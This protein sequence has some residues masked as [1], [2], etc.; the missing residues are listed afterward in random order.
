MRSGSRHRGEAGGGWSAFPPLLATNG[1]IHKGDCDMRTGAI[2]ARGS[3]RALKWMALLGVVF[4]LGGG[5]A[6]AQVTGTAVI[7][8][9]DHG[10]SKKIVVVDL[11][12]DV[13]GTNVP[14]SS[15][16]VGTNQAER[17]TGLSGSSPGGDEF[18]LAFVGDLALGATIAYTP[19]PDAT[20]ELKM[21]DG[22]DDGTDPDQVATFTLTTTEEDNAPVLPSISPVTVKHGE[23][24]TV[25]EPAGKLP[26]VTGGSGTGNITYVASPA[27][28][29]GLTIVTT[30]GD[31]L[32]KIHGT[33]DSIGTLQVTWTATD[34]DSPAES[35]SRSFQL[36][37]QGVPAKPDEPTVESAASGSLMVSWSAPM[38]NGSAITHYQVR[39]QG[40][41]VS[42][43]LETATLAASAGTMTTLTGLTNGTEYS[44]GV[45]A[46]NGIGWSDYSDSGKG[47]PAA[48]AVTA[49]GM[50]T[51]TAT[52]G[53]GQVTLAWAAVTGATKYQY[54]YA[55]TGSTMGDWMPEDGQ[56]TMTATVD[57][58]TNGMEYT[59][60]VRAGNDAGYGDPGMDTG[61]PMAPPAAPTVEVSA[62]PLTIAEGGESTITATA[63]R[64]V[65][66]S[67][68]AVTVN[69]SVVPTAGATLSADSITIAVGEMS[70]TVTLTAAE[71]DDDY[72]DET[73]TV[74]ASGTGIAGNQSVE[75]TV[76]DNDT[77]PTTTDPIGRIIK[78][79]LDE[80]RERDID[81]KRL[82]I[83]EGVHTK[84]SVTIEWTDV[85]LQSLTAGDYVT[86]VLSTSWGGADLTE[87]LSPVEFDHDVNQHGHNVRVKIPKLAAGKRVASS[88]GS[89]QFTVGQDDDAE[90]EVFRFWVVNDDEFNPL[91]VVE[92]L[93][94]VIEDDETQGIELK[95]KGSGFIYEG[96]DDVVYEVNAKPARV[97]L[98]LDVRFDLEDV[99]GQ[100]VSSGRNRLTRAGATIEPGP[101]Q[102]ESV[103]ITLDKNDE[104]REDD[105]LKIMAEVVSYALDTGAYKGITSQEREFDVLD[106]HK[107]PKLTVSPPTGTVE[108]GGE[109]EL[110]VTINRNPPDT[111]AVGSETRQYTS[112]AVDVMLTAGAGTTAGMGDYQLPATVKF[113]KHSGKASDGWT[114][115]MTVMVK[116]LPDDDLDDGE[117]LAIDAMVS[118]TET[119]RGTD[120][121]SYH[122]SDGEGTMLTIK[123]ATGKL[124]WARTPEE[125]E[126]AVMAAKKAGMGDDMMFTAGEMIE[127][128]GNDLFGSA[129]GVSV[130]YTAMVEGDAV[131]ESVSGG[132]VTITAEKMGMAKVTITARA[133]R[134]SGAVTINDQTDPREASIT[135][136]LEVGLVALSIMLS[137]PEDMNMNLVE[138][139]MGGMVTATAN[140]DVTENTVVNLMRDRAMSSAGDEDFTVEPIT[141]MAGQMKGSTMVM[142]VEDNM[143][144]NEGN[145]AEE[146]VL[147]GMVADNAGE[148]TGDGVKFY[149]WD[150]AVPALPVIAQLLLAALMAVGGYRRYRRR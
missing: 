97:Q 43:W 11:D 18:T 25:A 42:S 113:D 150:A 49:P 35:V 141:I 133:S 53:D 46:L 72:E 90:A 100:T 107:L 9:E 41:G 26:P 119:S 17:I 5:E 68:G 21:A 8:T 123:D 81:G 98:A 45:R 145:M 66:A 129:E 137:G 2:F 138:G 22:D 40:K 117:M 125:V 111:I 130:G 83:G 57:G 112:E 16:S 127:L 86:V 131:S 136:A 76:T 24:T 23:A 114:Q 69:L 135:I 54:A 58:L 149:I 36:S 27:S 28:P 134:P 96:G 15:F 79:E 118:G 93:P 99:M 108:E 110:T 101:D 38:D 94:I 88:T 29:F 64:M 20:R 19:P 128:E 95:R 146:L 92:T 74:V 3:C 6:L 143:M 56:S 91:S 48:P 104:N 109:I 78:I 37:V 14:A 71:D 4:A 140:R 102:K 121:D 65:M 144:E 147:Y 80:A 44:V 115:S 33:P 77:R 82:H 59:F 122:A 34:T 61:T 52:A 50:P 70:G 87:W 67:D 30:A 62:D 31:D 63:N 85:E 12:T 84:V 89:V 32:G 106:V 7:E 13:W 1:R 39:Y 73:V 51:V 47:T 75:I 142:A 55:R 105:K 124:V 139:G 60:Y 148:I 10:Y 120:K 116:A 103:T 126:A 132:V